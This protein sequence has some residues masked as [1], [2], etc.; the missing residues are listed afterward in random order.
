MNDHTFVLAWL[1]AFMLT[2]TVE[3]A[4]H[5]HAPGLPTP[6]RQR[7]A[8]GFGASAITHPMV[9]F[10]IPP[11]VTQAL[12]LPDFETEFWIAVAIAEAF[13]LSVETLWLFLF[14]ARLPHALAVAAIANATSFTI[15]LV[16]YQRLGW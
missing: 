15:G 1:Q 4:I 13:A 5:A 14:G 6:L 3:L 9:W 12:S 11:L 10:V 8:I 2:Q 16:C 7:L